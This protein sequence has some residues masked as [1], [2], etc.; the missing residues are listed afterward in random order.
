MRWRLVITGEGPALSTPAVPTDA[1]A[2]AA[3]V[4][5]LFEGQKLTGATFQVDANNV[6]LLRK[7]KTEKPTAPLA[8]EPPVI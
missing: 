8:P 1:Q 6:N 3:D 4:L 5:S 2:Q 7:T